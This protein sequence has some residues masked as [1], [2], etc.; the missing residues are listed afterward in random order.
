MNYS[1]RG[2]AVWDTWYMVAPDPKKRK[3]PEDIVHVYHLQRR[4]PRSRAS[5]F[6]ND[7]L[8]HATS[9]D[10]VNWRQQPPAFGPDPDNPFDNWQ[11][12]TGCALWREG[13]AYLYYTM[14]GDAEPGEQRIGLATSPD[15]FRWERYAQNPVIQPDPQWYATS[16][17]PTPGTVDCRDLVVVP[18]PAGGWLGFYATRQPGEEL[19]ETSAIACVASDDLIHW[20]HRPPAFA[21]GK[22]ACVEVPDVFEMD[23]KW[24]MTCLTGEWYGNRG[25]FTDPWAIAGTMYAVS[26]R[27]EGPYE[28]LDDNCYV[29]GGLDAPISCRTVSLNG[30]RYVLYTDRERE[31]RTNAGGT[32]FGTITTP[33]EVQ[34]S[35]DHLVVA[36]SDLIEKRVTGEMIGPKKPP[37]LHLVESW[38][39]IWR[40]APASRWEW[41]DSIVGESRTAWGVAQIDATADNFIF[42]AE[43]ELLSGRGA[44]LAFRMDDGRAGAVVAYDAEDRCLYLYGPDVV[45]LGT[46]TPRRQVARNVGRQFTLKVVARGEHIE[47]YVNDQ[48]LLTTVWYGPPS[49]RL[50]LYVDCGRAAFSDVRARGLKVDVPK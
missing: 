24:Y 34:T 36:Y 39:Q 8:G 48:F 19:P 21:N 3:K 42:E 6:V 20:Q 43:V 17:K 7:S 41:G 11:P 30:R 4:R 5:D 28:E 2:L 12:W 50:G 18:N 1:P 29:V 23:G 27:P 22:Y 14:R 47:G 38:G 25:L 16:R 44:G 13:Q 37:K 10:L 31:G 9:T 46:Y 15:G 32:F 40:G 45:S 26:D 35:G 49:G 33:K